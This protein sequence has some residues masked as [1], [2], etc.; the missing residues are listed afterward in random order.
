MGL[1]DVEIAIKKLDRQSQQ[2]L[3]Q[4]LPKLLGISSETVGWLKAAESSFEFWDNEEDTVY[5]QLSY[6]TPALQ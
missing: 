2:K 5:D 1:E 4:D 3:L 6:N